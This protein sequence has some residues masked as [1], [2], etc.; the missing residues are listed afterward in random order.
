MCDAGK[1]ALSWSDGYEEGKAEGLLQAFMFL[2]DYAYEQN[3]DTRM[4]IRKAAMAL[5]DFYR[6]K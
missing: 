3:S 6:S 1:R 5:R 2:G 4:K